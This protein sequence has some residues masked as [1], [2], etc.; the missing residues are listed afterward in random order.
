MLPGGLLELD[1]SPTRARTTGWNGS[2]DAHELFTQQLLPVSAHGAIEARASPPNTQQ[3]RPPPPTTTTTRLGPL[4]TLWKGLRIEA[5]G[6]W[7]AAVES[8][9]N[10][11]LDHWQ[12]ARPTTPLDAVGMQPL[13]SS[14]K[15]QRRDSSSSEVM[16]A[17]VAG[18]QRRH[19]A[20]ATTSQHR[21]EHNKRQKLQGPLQSERAISQSDK[22]HRQQGRNA[23]PTKPI[24][25]KPTRPNAPSHGITRPSGHS[26]SS[27]E[28]HVHFDLPLSTAS[29]MQPDAALIQT[30]QVATALLG[31]SNG[32]QAVAQSWRT[33]RHSETQ[34][35]EPSQRPATRN[36]AVGPTSP[37]R[38][39][40]ELEAEVERLRHEVSLNTTERPISLYSL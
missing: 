35:R 17:T 15:R 4:S 33:A 40:Q 10:K 24:L 11:N 32:F 23:S 38:R 31:S 28:N 30:T 21:S 3:Q 22:A 2:P 26:E 14:S 12:L 37:Q 34:R 18:H 7:R 1:D 8:N 29:P 19:S 6:F 5:T 36:I 39:I 16:C 20:T 27:K 13:R 25:H 9:E